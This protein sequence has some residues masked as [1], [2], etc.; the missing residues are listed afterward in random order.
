MDHNEVANIYNTEA[1]EE[2]AEH[3]EGMALLKDDL[4]GLKKKGKR[5]KR[6]RRNFSQTELTEVDIKQEKLPATGK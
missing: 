2:E 4:K 6:Q 1:L 3:E 5:I